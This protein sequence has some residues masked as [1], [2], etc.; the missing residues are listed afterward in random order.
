MKTDGGR[1]GVLV[2]QIQNCVA[3]SIRDVG[4]GSNLEIQTNTVDMLIVR[5]GKGATLQGGLI[6]EGS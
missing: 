4:Q 3:V 2:G 1:T 6:R 5:G